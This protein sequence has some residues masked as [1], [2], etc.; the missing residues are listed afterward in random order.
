MPDIFE[1][2]VPASSHPSASSQLQAFATL[3]FYSRIQSSKRIQGSFFRRDEC[4]PAECP[5]GTVVAAVG[6]YV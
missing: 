6:R 1:S 2:K 4:T 5:S 3:H